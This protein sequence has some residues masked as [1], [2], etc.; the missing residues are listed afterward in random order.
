MPKGT[1]RLRLAFTAAHRESTS[2][3]CWMPL[4]ETRIG[5]A[6]RAHARMYSLIRCVSCSS[7][8]GAST[9]ASL[10]I[11]SPISRTPRS[12]WSISASSPAVPEAQAVAGGRHRRRA[13]AWSIVAARAGGGRF[14]ALVSVQG[15]DC[16]CC[17][18]AP[19]RLAA[20]EARARAGPWR[21]LQAFWRSCGASGFALPEALNV[22]RLD[23]GLDWLMHWDARKAKE[24]L[25]LPR[26]RARRPGRRHRAAF[27]ERGDLGEPASSG[28]RTAA[29]SCP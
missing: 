12:P 8:A 11:S 9:P 7:M 18:V 27:D 26:P 6:R 29:M 28:R 4:P 3:D 25:E 2:I 15:F 22:A 23:E 21:N 13:L 14:R 19:S 20:L 1:A 10:P 17:H 24:E 16:F 5:R